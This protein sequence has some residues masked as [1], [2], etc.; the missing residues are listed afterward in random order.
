MDFLE[1]E[2]EELHNSQVRRI[3]IL[4]SNVATTQNIIVLW[5]N[6]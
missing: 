2:H 6:Y 4:V 3:M 5:I 1:K